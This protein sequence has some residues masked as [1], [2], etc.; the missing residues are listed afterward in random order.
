MKAFFNRTQEQFFDKNQTTTLK[1]ICIILVFI[2]HFFQYT[3]Y[4]YHTV[5]LN[6]LGPVSV[7]IFFFVAGYTALLKLERMKPEKYEFFLADRALRLYLPFTLIAITYSNFL[8]GV[9][10]MYIASYLAYKFIGPKYRA[11][12]IFCM[13]LV[14]IIVCVRLKMGSWW[15]DRVIG[16]SFGA[17]FAVYK[18]HIIRLFQNKFS[19]RTTFLI[20]LVCA[21]LL[22][23]Q[24]GQNGKFYLL[25]SIVFAFFECMFMLAFYYIFHFEMKIFIFIGNISFE[26]FCIHQALFVLLDSFVDS[27]Y[28][29]FIVSFAASVIISLIVQKLW[30]RILKAFK[31]VEEKA[32]K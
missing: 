18:D 32:Y 19:R 23:F 3:A 17:M 25:A 22:A 14:F 15:Y 2:N 26:I 8:T 31:A 30:N 24:M 6:L 16:Y 28:M 7:N 5:F 1:G 27:H 11:L 9:L 4:P 29:L 13:N 10:C 12:F 21:S 20:S